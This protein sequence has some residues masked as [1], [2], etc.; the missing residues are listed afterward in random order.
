VVSQP[1]LRDGRPADLI[2]VAPVLN[3]PARGQPAPGE[4]VA[5]V[6]QRYDQVGLWVAIV[7]TFG[8]Q[9]AGVAPVVVQSWLRYG[10]AASGAVT[11]LV[12]TALGVAAAVVV[13][14]GGGFSLALP[15][16]VCPILLAG[17]VLG[18]LMAPDGVIGHFNWQFAIA[19]G[20]RTSRP[21]RIAS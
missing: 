7:V 2:S 1:A 16:A 15:L 4:S 20:P 8:W 9:L 3:Q 14:R 12:F 18:S 5:D 10:L 13:L 17:S 11:W 21:R 19:P 6:E